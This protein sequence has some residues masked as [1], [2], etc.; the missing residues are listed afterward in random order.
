MA[1]RVKPLPKM[2][3]GLLLFGLLVGGFKYLVS[4]GVISM[5]GHAAEVPK[6]AALPALADNASTPTVAAIPLPSEKPITKGTEVR[7]MVWAWTAQTS[8]M[9]ANGGVDTTEGSLM[10]QHGVKMHF[11]R[12]DDTAKMAAQLMALSKGLNSDPNTKDGQHF[13]ILMGDGTPSWFSGL[14]PTLKKICPDCTAEVIGSAGYSRGEDKLMGPA[15]WRDNPKAAKG[16]LIAGVLRDGDWNIAMKWAGDNGLKNNPDETTW[17]PDA[18][19]WV[20]T[21]TYIDAAKKY[22]LNVCEDRKV[23]KDGKPNGETKHVCVN[24]VV[25]WTPGDVDIAKGR[26]GLVP[27]VSTHEY[28]A[29]MPAAII[30]IKKW[31]AAHRDV[32]TGILQAVF[33]ASDQVKSNPAALHKGAEISAKVYGE[34]DAAYWERY[35]KGVTETDKQG[36]PVALGGSV[37]SN[38]ADNMQLFGLAP[39]SINLFNATYTSFGDIAVQQYPKLVASYPKTEEILNTSYLKDVASKST[40]TTSADLPTFQ[41]G[42]DLK[43]VVSKKAW[44]ITFQTGSASFSPEAKATLEALSKDLSIT[45]LAV[46]IDGHT[47]DTGD[48]G[49]N[50]A[51]S[52]ARAKAV[53]DWLHSQSASTFPNERFI[54]NG[55]GQSKPVATNQTEAGR[56][57]NRRVDIVMG[58]Q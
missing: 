47:D 53:R 48:A 8:L 52:E 57:K 43:R 39:G 34:Q 32:V 51:L 18:L 3:L 6:V 28:R 41:S 21:D 5:P 33:E 25:T 9:F 4:S 50:K 16:S 22:V 37:V 58:S 42:V 46:E 2:L 54:V 7:M 29:Q 11:T 23:V 24:G 44:S 10:A 45:E 17:D 13:V 1:T 20:A 19:N 30:G 14:N 15:E 35:F 38:L 56:A 40:A 12:E 49:N 31:N 26:G 27:I 36:L 55:Y